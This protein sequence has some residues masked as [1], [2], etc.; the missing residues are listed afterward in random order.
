MDGMYGYIDAGKL[1][2]FSNNHIA[3][4]DFADDDWD[5]ASGPLSHWKED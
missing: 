3:G 2:D 1:M 5:N 4:I